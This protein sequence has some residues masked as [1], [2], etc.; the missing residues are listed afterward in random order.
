MLAVIHT[1][2]LVLRSVVVPALLL[3]VLLA[4][5]ATDAKNASGLELTE[6][7]LAAVL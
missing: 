3:G 1:T 6:A 4:L 2:G 7:V 5:G